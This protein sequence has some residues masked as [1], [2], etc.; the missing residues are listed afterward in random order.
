[1]AD[2]ILSTLAPRRCDTVNILSSVHSFH[3][4]GCNTWTSIISGLCIMVMTHTTAPNINATGSTCPNLRSVTTLSKHCQWSSEL[5]QEIFTPVPLGVI[6]N[7]PEFSNESVILAII[8]A[9]LDKIFHLLFFQP[10]QWSGVHWRWRW[11]VC[12]RSIQ[13]TVGIFLAWYSGRII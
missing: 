4:L 5:V 12:Y 11:S 6:L 7:L 3:P 13:Y 10:P 1:M 8:Q 9:L 2:V